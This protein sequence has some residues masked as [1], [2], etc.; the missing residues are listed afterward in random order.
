VSSSTPYHT[1]LNTSQFSVDTPVW[2]C[3]KEEG[4]ILKNK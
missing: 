4:K 1:Q 3:K 2:A